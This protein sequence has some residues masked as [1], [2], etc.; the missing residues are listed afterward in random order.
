M[1]IHGGAERVVLEEAKMMAD[2]GNEVFIVS[3][4]HS[5]KIPDTI[6]FYNG[7]IRNVFLPYRIRFSKS[8]FG[9]GLSLMSAFYNPITLRYLR[10]VL[11][12]EQPDIVHIH[13]LGEISI[14][15]LKV[16]RRLGIKTVQTFHGY[17]FECPRGSLTK[18]SGK[19]CN[20]PPIYCK[21]YRE[22]YRSL[23]KSC[24]H[25]IAI[26]SYVK[27]RLLNAGYSPNMITVLPNSI[28]VE[29]PGLDNKRPNMP[30][31]ILFVG[32]MSKVKGV[33]VLLEALTKIYGV[34]DKY[35]VN[36]I[37][38]GEDL[39]S[40]QR[41]AK[42]YSL[43]VNFLGK[44]SDRVLKKYYK[45]A[46]IV[47]V[48][49]L[50]PELCPMV[51]LEAAAHGCPVIASNIGG[52]SDVVLH[53]KTG[54]LFNP[55]DADELAFFIES[56]LHNEELALKMGFEARR[57]AANFSN[58]KKLVKLLKIYDTVLYR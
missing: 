3:L 48:P 12:K 22:I 25:I 44:V 34:G 33:H 24:D 9:K 41:L 35:I 46:W 43:S 7:K 8:I 49:S 21:L 38:D 20:N 42:L 14:G 54:F 31:E 50:F 45:K 40:F 23:M 55:N 29:S 53:G 56:L 1:I 18:I 4:K 11:V 13:Q 19:I 5:Q 36:L 57:F 51:P 10:K 27:L 37:G 15:A 52:M 16:I 17:Y 58:E 30:K 6:Y 26:S 47:V 39:T 2:S 28:Y 32:R